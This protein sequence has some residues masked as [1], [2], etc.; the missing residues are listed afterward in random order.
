M[1]SPI[2]VI[3]T[4]STSQASE[5]ARTQWTPAALFVA[6]SNDGSTQQAQ[7]D[8]GKIHGQSLVAPQKKPQIFSLGLPK[9]APNNGKYGSPN[10]SVSGYF[11]LTFHTFPFRSIQTQGKTLK[12]S[13][14]PSKVKN[15]QNSNCRFGFH[16]CIFTFLWFQ[17][18]WRF[19]DFAVS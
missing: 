11:L 16:C 5:H 12:V 1:E 4:S 14:P 2:Y 7:Q 13:P 15:D 9:I 18:L 19:V 17:L 3:F 6:P 10:L 8:P